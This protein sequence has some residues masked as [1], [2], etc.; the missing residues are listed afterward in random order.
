[1]MNNQLAFFFVIATDLEFTTRYA[2]TN[3]KVSREDI[4]TLNCFAMTER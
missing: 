3:L 2:I 1:M 4:A